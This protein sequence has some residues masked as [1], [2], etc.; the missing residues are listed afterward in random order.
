[1]RAWTLALL[2]LTIAP[3]AACDLNPQ[4]FPP[5]EQPD[6]AAGGSG[7]DNDGAETPNPPAAT[8]GGFV[9]D[10]SVVDSAAGNEDSAAPPVDADAAADAGLGDA[11]RDAPSDAPTDAPADAATDAPAD[12]TSDANVD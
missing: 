5:G 4:P 8:D 12:A 2:T 10:A 6:G 9:H 3:A 11:S 1:M 7:R